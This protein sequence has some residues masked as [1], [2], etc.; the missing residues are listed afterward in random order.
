RRIFT[1]NFWRNIW[2]QFG[3]CLQ[4][5]SAYH[6]ETNGQTERA[7]QTMDQLICTT[8]DDEADWEQQLP[9][10]EFA[11]NNALSA[12]T[13]QSPFYLNYEQNLTVP[14]TPN[15]ENLV[16]RAQQL[17]ETLKNA[18]ER[19]AEAIKRAN[20]I[21]K[22]NA[23]LHQRALTYKAGDLVLFDTQKLRL[24]IVPK[25]HPRYSGSFTISHIISSI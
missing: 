4:L 24:P 11:Y 15:P 16:P 2:E 21:S 6:P 9:L 8:C 14:L 17:A 20:I 1:S 10:I 25:L 23:N 18:L 22:R 19:V 13:R 7:N 12:T 3:T 5:S